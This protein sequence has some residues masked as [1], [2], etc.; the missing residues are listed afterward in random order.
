MDVKITKRIVSKYG[1]IH[2][3]QVRDRELP[4]E[5]SSSICSFRCSCHEM[6]EETMIAI[7]P[8]ISWKNDAISF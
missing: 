4:V 5:S 2:A 8:D 7:G 3:F 6:D 1:P